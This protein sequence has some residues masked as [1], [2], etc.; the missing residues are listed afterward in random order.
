[1]LVLGGRNA[2]GS[3]LHVVLGPE[4][5]LHQDLHGAAILDVT[6]LLAAMSGTDKVF[7]SLT[8]CRSEQITS[9]ILTGS[10]IPFMNSFTNQHAAVPASSHT[11]NG[12]TSAQETTETPREKCQY[13]AKPAVLL[14]I[15]GFKICQ[16]CAA[17]ELG[18]RLKKK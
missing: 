3:V 17:I 10:K 1:M 8:R 14:P 7:M 18:R 5:E 6:P 2:I 16:S 12:T 9:S 15:T 13:C 11:E 4:S